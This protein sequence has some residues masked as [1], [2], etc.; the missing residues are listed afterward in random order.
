M[1]ASSTTILG[2]LSA[3][4]QFAIPVYQRPYSWKI[5]QCKQFWKDIIDAGRTEQSHFIGSIVYIEEAK[6]TA[7]N[8][9][10]KMVIDGQQRLTTMMLLLEALA[11]HLPDDYS[12]RESS[13][14]K[15]LRHYYLR[16]EVETGNTRYKLLLSKTDKE[17]L[18]ALLDQLPLPATSSVRITENFRFFKD[19]IAK[20]KDF[21]TILDGLNRL[22]VVDIALEMGK[23]NPQ[24]I[25]ESLNSTGLRLSQADL[26]RNYLLMGLPQGEQKQLYEGYWWPMEN[27]FGQEA[28]QNYFD[29]FMRDYLSLRAGQTPTMALIY[30][31]FKGRV[32]RENIAPTVKDIHKTA[33]RYTRLALGHEPSATLRPIFVHIALLVQVAWPFLLKVYEDYEAQ[34]IREKDF[35]EI[36]SMVENYVFRRAICELPPNSLDKTFTNILRQATLNKVDSVDYVASVKAAFLLLKDKRRF[37][38]DDEFTNALLT[39]NIYKSKIAHYFLCKLERH[40]SGKEQADLSTCTIEHIMPQTMTEAWQKEL[41]EDWQGIHAKCVHTAGNLTLTG[42]NPEY[43]NRPFAAKR[44]DAKGYKESIFSLNSSLSEVEQWNE[45]AI[46]HRA[47]MLAHEAVK[48]WPLPFMDEVELAN[49]APQKNGATYTLEDHPHA[50]SGPMRELFQHL[51]QEIL[52]LDDGLHKEI[53]KLYIAYKIKTNI[54]DIVP[55]KAKLRISLNMPFEALDD[56]R[57]VAK[58]ASKLGRWGNGGVEVGINTMDD[59]PYTMELIKQAVAYHN[60]SNYSME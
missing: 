18:C 45:T 8:P 20:T 54:V 17:T 10:P 56:P 1:Q 39:R 33:S 32:Q 31:T 25:F 35:V 2:L 27:D 44:D 51:R 41:G 55:Q 14:P 13:M 7:T 26:I 36:A 38:R 60:R 53:L 58:D 30:E 34:I 3:V 22:L 9:A 5:E 57:N 40:L 47:T 50:Y 52:G 21:G 48:I 46:R 23:D 43:G 15:H 42:Y 28:Y 24:L 11:R 49:F 6:G 29:F 4:K 19:A 16:N 12:E 37:P 59:V